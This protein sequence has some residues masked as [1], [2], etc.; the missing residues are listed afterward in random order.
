MPGA[1]V[2]LATFQGA[3]HLSAQLGSLAAQE[4][5][6]LRVVASD[7]GSTD[8]TRAILAA[9]AAQHGILA[10]QHEGPRRGSA[11]NFLHLVA[12]AEPDGGLL[13][14]CDQDDV[15]LPGKLARAAAMLEG[16]AGPALWIGRVSVCDEALARCAP[17]P[18]PRDPSFGHALAEA[19]GPG[20]AMVMNAAAWALLRAAARAGEAEGVP[21]H[22]WWAT[23]MV[24]GAGGRAILDDLPTT[25]YRQHGRNALG[26]GHGAAEV[27]RGPL[28][29]LRGDFA[30]DARAQRAGLGRSAHRLTAEARAA[31]AA[32]DALPSHPPLARIRSLPEAGVRRGGRGAQAG[33]LL[34]AALGRL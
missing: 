4:G 2:L 28:R 23:Q 33:L 11:A 17:A 16:L 5:V 30:R 15:W 26:S 10:A 29:M 32:L 22:D 18:V 3:R 20:H 6:A 25:L 12:L 24:L 8:G 27:L 19:L 13:A 34:L 9:F 1:T 14:F 7:D 31:L 21:H